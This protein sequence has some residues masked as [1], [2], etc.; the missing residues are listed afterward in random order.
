VFQLHWESSA[1]LTDYLGQVYE[2][3]GLVLNVDEDGIV[4][5]VGDTYEAGVRTNVSGVAR[6]LILETISS[7][8][9]YTGHLVRGDNAVK[10]GLSIGNDFFIDVD[11]LLTLRSTSVPVETFDESMIAYHEMF[12]S[13]RGTGDPVQGSGLP[14]P[15]PTVDAV[16]A[17]RSKLG[18]PLRTSYFARQ[19]PPYGLERLG[20]PFQGGQVTFFNY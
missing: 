2:E 17:I 1:D 6:S 4:T 18:L 13:V 11:D 9:T 12:H 20:V 16:N 19:L 14:N 3:T 8:D 5:V 7:E 15:G 10:G